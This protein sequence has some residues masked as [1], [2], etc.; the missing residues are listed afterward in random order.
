M[1]PVEKAVNGGSK[2]NA[3]IGNEDHPAEQGI[4]GRKYFTAG[5]CN[6]DYRAH[7]TEDHAGIVNRIDP[8][9]ASEVMVSKNPDQQTYKHYSESD[10]ETF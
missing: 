6:I 2:D 9:N 3:D 10:Q 7:T 5:G 8:C 4:K 1:Q